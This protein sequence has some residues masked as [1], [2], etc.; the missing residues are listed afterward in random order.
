M[1]RS[2]VPGLGFAR[3]AL[4]LLAAWLALA[5]PAPGQQFQRKVPFEGTH[6]FR[7]LLA[8]FQARPLEQIEELRGCNPADTLLIVFG[9]PAVLKEIAQ[10][11]GGLAR[12]RQAGGSILIAT[13]QPDQANLRDLRIVVNGNLVRQHEKGAYRGQQDC[14]QLS[15]FLAPRQ[16]RH[17]LFAH[18]E[19]PVATNRPSYLYLFPDSEL[20]NLAPVVL[21]EPAAPV[22][23]WR[24]E[25]ETRRSRHFSKVHV[26]SPVL[27]AG[28]GADS[29]PA[30]RAV[31]LAGHGIFMNGMMGQRDNDNFAFAFNCLHWLTGADQGQRKRVLFV[32]DGQVHSNF[33][34]PLTEKMPL[35]LPPT[36]VMNDLLR[37]LEEENQFNRFLLEGLGRSRIVQIVFVLL[38]VA[39]IGYGLRRLAVGRHRVELALPLVDRSVA[40]RLEGPPVLAQRRA[41]LLRQGNLWEAARALARQ[42][43]EKPGVPGGNPTAM[44]ALVLKGGCWQR[45]KLRRQCR[46]LWDLAYGAEAVPVSRRRLARV[47]AAAEHVGAAWDRGTLRFLQH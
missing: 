35:P 28:T 20:E 32:E 1:K 7:N 26:A 37:G 4:G 36:R 11:T 33:T 25:L 30:G 24:R 21:L 45:W 34:V 18:L 41:E 46:W 13:D 3:L 8:T 12:F 10:V 42:C 47:R 40:C 44:P 14:P 9:A 29:R 22:V 15:S 23:L 38:S 31:V 6:S 43:F 19:R 5:A 17:P 39:L 16:D 2:S 27:L